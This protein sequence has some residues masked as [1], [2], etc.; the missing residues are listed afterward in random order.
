MRRYHLSLP[1]KFISCKWLMLF[2]LG[3]H[4]HSGWAQ[5]DTCMA[6]MSSYES[7]IQNSSPED[8][9]WFRKDFVPAL[10]AS[11]LTSI[12][13]Q[14]VQSTLASLQEA[15]ISPLNGM[16]GYLYA[17][18]DQINR[19]DTARWFEWHSIIS[20]MLGDRKLRKELGQFLNGSEQLLSSNILWTGPRHAWELRG[21][22]WHFR[23]VDDVPMLRFDSCDLFV[24]HEGDTLMFE[25][26]AGQWDLTDANCEIS[27]SKLP[28]IGTDFDPATTFVML[29]A[30]T[31]DLKQDDVREDEV[32]FYSSFSSTPLTG[33]LVA[34][35]EA[36]KSAKAKDYPTIRCREDQVILDSLYSSFR[37]QGGLQVR[38]STIRGISKSGQSAMME[39]IR[40]DTVFMRFQFEEVTLS[41]N[42][43]NG[44][45]SQL[46]LYYNGDTLSHPNC[47]V[48]YE[49][50]TGIISVTRQQNGLGQ[51][52][53]I[54]RYHNL[55][56][57][58]EGFTWKLGQPQIEIGFP[59]IADS[60]TGTFLSS[61]Y[62]E[63]QTFDR[64][65]GI[66]PIHPV[67]ELYRFVKSSGLTSFTSI[68]YAYYIKL[69]EVQA[70][71]ALMNLA[72]AGYVDYD[73]DQKIARVQ[74][75]T[76]QHIGYVTNKK[77]HDMIRFYSAPK[78]GNNAE[79]SL[80][81]GFMQINGVDQLVLSNSRGISI[82]PENSEVTVSKNLN[83]VLNGLVDAGNLR[84]RGTGM[85]F[86]YER[87]TIDFRKIEEVRLSINDFESLDYRG[88]PEKIWLKNALENISGKLAID[89]PGNRSG[90]WSMDHP[91]YPKFT[92]NE[93]SFVYYDSPAL[94]NGAYNRNNFYYAVMPFELNGLDQLTREDLK[95]DGTLV[96]SGIVPEIEQP[97]VV[98][99]DNYLGL[100]S[101]T[102]PSGT[103][104]YGG[105]AKFTSSLSLD[106]SGLR[107]EGEIDF[108][109]AHA[110]GEA[111]VFLPDSI[112]GPFVTMNNAADAVSD[113]PDARGANGT[114]HFN[115]SENRLRFY[116]GREPMWI[117]ED[118]AHLTGKLE[119]NLSG[120]SGA[121]TLDLKKAA[122]QA[123]DFRFNSRKTV[124]QHA[125]FELF[126]K[127][128]SLSAFE[129][130]NV[131][132][133]IDFDERLGEFTPN[134]GETAIEL[135]IQQYR[136]YMDKFRWFMDEDEID[137][138]SNRDVASL[139]LNFSE[140][141]VH[142]NFISTHPAQDS[143]HFLSSHATYL[144]GTDVLNCQGV[145]EMAVADARVFPDS[146]KVTIRA[147]AAMDPLKNARVIANTTTQHHIIEEA[148]LVITGRYGYT[149]NGAYQYVGVD[150]SI[151]PLILDELYVDESFQTRGTGA[152]YSR[153]AFLLN[154]YFAF[155]G[156][157]ELS[158]SEEFLVFDGGARMTEENELFK[159][160]WIKFR[161]P[162]N[163]KNVEIPISNPL[164][165]VDGDPLACGIMASSRP[166][167]TL[168][169]AF[170]DPLGDANDAS[171]IA[172]EGALR[173]RDGIY[174][175]G[176]LEV[177]ENP[178][179]I[180][181]QITLNPKT[182]KLSGSGRIRM[183]LDFGMSDH[184]MVGN[185]E[186]D[187]KG[188][189]HFEGT[190][191]L[192]YHFHA[193]LFERMAL[194]IPSW[195][196]SEPLDFASTNYEQALTTWLGEDDSQKIIN[197]LA[198]TG[199]F[200]NVPK[201]M[202]NGV[203][204]TGVDLVWNDGEEMWTSGS[205]FG[206]VSLGK[207]ALFMNIPAK[208]ELKRSRSG[209]NFVL[210]LHGDEENW[211]YHTYK[212][213]NG[214]EGTLSINTS[215]LVF[216]DILTEI[217]ADKRKDKTKDGKTTEFK[218]M[219]SRRLRDNLVDTYRDFD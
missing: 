104:L 84:M 111:L 63:K 109:S 93:T 59:L 96:S 75:R 134:S 95:L 55:E 65:Q 12:Q 178:N 130:K 40:E 127:S 56:W 17:V 37:Y 1:F 194:Q 101:V 208:L 141:R 27:P 66:D 83:M 140:K 120:L 91:S 159:M 73:V 80:L 72:N 121:G 67:V 98:M 146:G 18:Q 31:V 145:K 82:M 167:F 126:G 30:R 184:D 81:N 155:A 214:K 57:N 162:I 147:K 47:D 64:L 196:V 23:I 89:H 33:D 26:V 182:G 174:S 204:L 175:V 103:N 42:G 29:P 97:L 209:D 107:G 117:Y 206:V 21:K 173:C 88:E 172:L 187:G 119:V 216:Y 153:D 14:D 149:G 102:P 148:N 171:V 165:D 116:S 212:L 193:D 28:W 177:F 48:R 118:E 142:S 138:I 112:I 190:V 78:K 158:A 46:E 22:P 71:I 122:L 100:T 205:K 61:N 169:P 19:Q 5:D 137:L 110:E 36:N 50:K 62:F 215:D 24:H 2:I 156:Q 32:V 198:L 11:H 54:D 139:P 68:D 92:S 51:Q 123:D 90:K 218:Y 8:A 129:T 166:P 176:T 219:A 179:A 3:F 77:D 10:C 94:Y 52:A 20:L 106:G 150:K 44:I 180:G 181:N 160:S 168:Y 200:K 13:K 202:Q 161:A 164:L 133:T 157:V 135:P 43:W 79:W 86:D 189:I 41:Q 151:Q 58:V 69:S 74:D 4:V 131:H 39:V 115:P 105:A 9:K 199:K 217:K 114:L 108:L 87:F 144:V 76:F 85:E 183:P 213:I 154:P 188:Q 152:V 124:S 211:Y 49:D 99:S 128:Q 7:G 136:C 132:S 70:Q 210:Y 197:D 143:L 125:A 185:I 195:Q 113:V 163:P 53:F 15:R 16:L 25:G 60:K 170:L 207:E 192:S 6:E 201:T 203:V 35:L 191:L 45:R 186:I 34:K 38:G